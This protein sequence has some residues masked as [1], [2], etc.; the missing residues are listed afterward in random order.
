MMLRHTPA[1]GD[2]SARWNRHLIRRLVVALRTAELYA[3]HNEAVEKVVLELTSHLK[4]GHPAGQHEIGL[5]ARNRTLFVNEERVRVTPSDYL[6]FRYLATLLERWSVGDLVV[7]PG[8]TET[9][10]RG[11]LYVLLE[12]PGDADDLVDRLR[13][14]RIQHIDVSPLP[15]ETTGSPGGAQPLQTYCAF[16]DVYQEMHEAV[17]GHRQIRTRRLRRV[18]QAVVD[19]VLR[20]ESV[21]LSMTTIK[22]FD[23]YLFSHS[24]N[25]AIIAV[26][27]GQRLGL[28][29]VQLGELCLAGFLH[30][31]GKVRVDRRIL[32]KDGPLTEE[33]WHDIRRHPVNGVHL[34]LAQ[35]QL[36]PGFLRA[37]VG[38]FEHH[39]DYDLSGYPALTAKKRITLFGRIIAI[40]DRYDAVTTARPYRRRNLTPYEGVRFL[41]SQAGTALDPSLVRILLD[42][43]GLYPPGTLVGLTGGE[44]AVVERPPRPGSPIDRPCVRRLGEEGQAALL[45]L[46]E[47][48][49]QGNLPPGIA[50][51]YNP[52][53]QGQVTCIDLTAV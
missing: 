30:D 18:T 16:L 21:L 27:M 15:E 42:V 13:A 2:I 51:V 29:K 39:L 3:S 6:S 4:Q 33:E 45:D 52:G 24:A 38:S 12:R 40:A 46:A 17:R 31:L 28:S 41:V 7:L 20:D 26:A 44:R 34:L 36:S 49:D 19:Q 8:I 5:A 35:G 47:T 48:D 10:V 23:D 25:V 14:E 37:I 9:E 1:A 11:L 22:E 53:N 50:T 43:M 32:E